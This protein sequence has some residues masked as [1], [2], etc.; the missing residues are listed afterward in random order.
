MNWTLQNT[1]VDERVEAAL[2]GWF[3]AA[4]RLCFVAQQTK[5]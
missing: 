2:A 3:S 5:N 1:R 4:K